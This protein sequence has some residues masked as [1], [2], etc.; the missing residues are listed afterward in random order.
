MSVVGTLKCEK[1]D[2]NVSNELIFVVEFLN[3]YIQQDQS[4]YYTN[5]NNNN[6]MIF[7]LL[8]LF[9]LWTIFPCH[10]QYIAFMV[11]NFFLDAMKF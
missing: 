2:K 10:T 4:Y 1:D 8:L 7:L 3:L 11:R 5:N 9:Y 6:N